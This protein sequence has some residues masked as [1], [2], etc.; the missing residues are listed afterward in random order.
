[1]THTVK[2][3]GVVNKAE[4][5]VFRERSLASTHVILQNWTTLCR[6]S[7]WPL[8]HHQS[9]HP[10]FLLKHTP[11]SPTQLPQ[12]SG[13]VGKESACNV[14]DPGSVLGW[15][16]SAGEANGNPFLYSC[17]KNSTDRD[18][19]GSSPKG[20]KVRH[21]WATE[22]TQ[23]ENLVK[24]ILGFLKN[25]LHTLW[26]SCHSWMFYLKL[27][28]QWSIV[29]NS[30]RFKREVIVLTTNS[31]LIS[32]PA[33]VVA[34]QWLSSVVSLLDPMDCSTPGFPVLHHLLEF[35]QTHVHWAGD[36]IHHLI[37]P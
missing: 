24:P 15:G 25:K 37:L 18:L 6:S 5:D 16:R 26:S 3:S 31:P 29:E 19:A 35:A 33:I 2:G 20:H 12:P 11:H 34:V 14:G 17:L 23:S 4:A 32:H 22:H 13:S 36:A 21:N 27:Q 10:Y 30:L 28:G 9:V 8:D 7:F 1:M